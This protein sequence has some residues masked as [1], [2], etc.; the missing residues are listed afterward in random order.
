MKIILL[1]YLLLC[2]PFVVWGQGKKG[3]A[4]EEWQVLH[5][6]QNIE[7]LVKHQLSQFDQ[8]HNTLFRLKNNSNKEITVIFK[9]SFM[10]ESSEVLL[11]MAE[12]KVN[13]YPKQSATL[14]AFRP[15]YGGIPKDIKLKIIKIKER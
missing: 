5:K 14:L 2:L 7:F 4:K 3:D 11:D 10:C 9:P 1:S 8:R 15:C 6:Q 13:I 12:V